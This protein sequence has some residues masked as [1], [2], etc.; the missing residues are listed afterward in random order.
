MSCKRDNIC[1]WFCFLLLLY[2][3]CLVKEIISVLDLVFLSSLF[4][5]IGDPGGGDD[6]DDGD[7]GGGEGE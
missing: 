1:P 4:F 7:D 5:L 3:L 2:L 6:D